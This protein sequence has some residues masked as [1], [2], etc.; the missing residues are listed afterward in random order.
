M[1]ER[2]SSKLFHHFVSEIEQCK[3]L[4]GHLTQWMNPNVQILLGCLNLCSE[5]LLHSV[6]LSITTGYHFQQFHDTLVQTQFHLFGTG[7]LNTQHILVM[8]LFSFD[9]ATGVL[10]LQ[11][12]QLAYCERSPANNIIGASN[13]GSIVAGE[14]LSVSI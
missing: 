10:R 4:Q 7:G 5:R 1:T 13:D 11:R 3:L 14:S 8:S 12:R 2:S 9:E 6:G